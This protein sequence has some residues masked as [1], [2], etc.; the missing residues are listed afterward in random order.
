MG[1]CNGRCKSCSLLGECP[2]DTV[3]CDACGKGI[4]PGC[5]VDVETEIV[6]RGRH[7]KKTVAVCQKCYERFYLSDNLNDLIF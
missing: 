5:G 2:E 1:R 7:Y 6:E 3:H 4:E